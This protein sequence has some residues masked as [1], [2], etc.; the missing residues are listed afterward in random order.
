MDGI[1]V[2]FVFEPGLKDDVW[3]VRASVGVALADSGGLVVAC[4]LVPILKGFPATNAR[5]LF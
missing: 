4:Q 1:D 3:T 5:P 2:V